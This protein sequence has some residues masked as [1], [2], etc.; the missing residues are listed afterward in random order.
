MEQHLFV[1]PH[2]KYSSQVKLNSVG[3]TTLF[4][5][6]HAEEVVGL[7]GGAGRG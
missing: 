4:V 1:S 6:S 3:V 7:G 5:G 2:T